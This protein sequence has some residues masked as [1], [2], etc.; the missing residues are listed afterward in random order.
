MQLRFHLSL[1]CG[2]LRFKYACVFLEGLSTSVWTLFDWWQKCISHSLSTEMNLSFHVTTIEIT[3]ASS[4]AWTHGYKVSPRAQLFSYPILKMTARGSP[5]YLHVPSCK[6]FIR[7]EEV[8][9]WAFKPKSSHS[10]SWFQERAHDSDGARES[11]YWDICVSF[12]QFT[13]IREIGYT[14]CLN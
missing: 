12:N 5:W 4:K 3:L 13:V 8:F 1:F 9:I 7:K 11:W 2:P 10:L 14:I 6:S